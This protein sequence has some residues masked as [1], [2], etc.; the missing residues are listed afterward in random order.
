MVK[1]KGIGIVLLLLFGLVL[2][3]ILNYSCLEGMTLGCESESGVLLWV[4]ES[5]WITMAYNEFR[6]M[7][8]RLLGADLGHSLK[9]SSFPTPGIGLGDWALLPSPSKLMGELEK[10]FVSVMVTFC[11]HLPPLSASQ[12]DKLAC[13]EKRNWGAVRKPLSDSE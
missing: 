1:H 2:V 7:G 10:S 4:T 3:I 9:P 6:G 12:T 13:F 8:F 11:W 5:Y